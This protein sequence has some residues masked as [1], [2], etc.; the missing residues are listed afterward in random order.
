[1]VK[2][3]LTPGPGDERAPVLTL[4]DGVEGGITWGD[5][6]Y[7]GQQRVEEGAEEAERLVLTRAGAAEQKCLL[8]QVR[9][10]IETSLSQLCYQF[11]D[12][13]FS[14]SWP[15]LW[16]TVQLKVLPYNLRQAGVLSA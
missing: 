1:M 6:G 9:P 11:L 12:R 5:L 13:V 8:T 15:G 4:R 2:L 7:R 16:N 14:R 3:V 10:A